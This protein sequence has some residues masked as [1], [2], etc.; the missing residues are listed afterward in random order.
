MTLEDM[1]DDPKRI[2][3]AWRKAARRIAGN[4]AAGL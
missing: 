4:I 2:E 1:R 3:D